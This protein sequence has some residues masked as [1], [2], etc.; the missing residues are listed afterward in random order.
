[1]SSVIADEDFLAVVDHNSVREFQVLRAPELVEDIAHLI[2]NNHTHDLKK[3]H[4]TD[5]KI[6]LCHSSLLSI[7]LDLRAKYF[8]SHRQN[9]LEDP[10]T[11]LLVQ[12]GTRLPGILHSDID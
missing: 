3:Y 6:A 7:T 4:L 9:I 2:K 5:K 12:V 8:R 10:Q 1:M 11:S